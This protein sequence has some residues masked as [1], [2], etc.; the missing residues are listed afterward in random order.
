M[1]Q[2]KLTTEHLTIY[3]GNKKIL[4]DIGIEIRGGEVVALLGANGAGKST[5]L[6]VLS[7]ESDGLHITNGSTIL[8]NHEN[9]LI[10]GKEQLAKKR[11]VTP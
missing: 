4:D 2:Q 11:A 1:K 3:R 8:R 5:L 6:N 10:L 7:G 9:L